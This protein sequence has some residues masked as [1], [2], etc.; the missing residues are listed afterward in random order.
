MSENC[1]DKVVN[2]K[3][4]GVGGAGNNVVDRMISGGIGGVEFVVVNTDR[5]ALK[6]SKCENKVLIGEKLTGGMGADANPEIGKQSAEE[7]RA[8]ISKAIEGADMAVIIA[9]MGGGTGT[10]AAPIIADLAHDAGIL[11]VGIVT[12]PVRFEGANR[13]KQA[14]AGIASLSDKVDSLIIIPNNHL[15]YAT[16]QKITFANAFGIASDVLKRAVSAIYGYTTAKGTRSD[17]N[18]MPDVKKRGTHNEFKKTGENAGSRNGH[19]KG[20]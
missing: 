7:S 5:Q 15:K 19:G 12:K 13:R 3:V 11:T 6:K 8:A 16:D 20:C 17:E 14:E 18:G 10:G 1:A 2:I 4:I 9:G